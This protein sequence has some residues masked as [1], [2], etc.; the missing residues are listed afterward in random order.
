M[1]FHVMTQ[2]PAERINPKE[3]FLLFATISYSLRRSVSC[4]G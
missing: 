4:R 3:G 2:T 1:R